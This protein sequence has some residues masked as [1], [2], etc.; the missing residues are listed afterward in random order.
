MRTRK[1]IKLKVV[2]V[3][4]LLVGLNANSSAKLNPMQESLRGVQAM[5]VDVVC[6][7]G[8][9]EASLNQQDIRDNL[10]NQLEQT[11]IKI[12]PRQFWQTVP[13]RCRLKVLLKFTSRPI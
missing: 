8:A 11:G 5:T 3:M 9:T 10:I 2:A 4:C 6:S 13:G 7:E 12:I 1:K